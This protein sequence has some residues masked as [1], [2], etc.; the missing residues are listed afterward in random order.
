MTKIFHQ[1]GYR[2]KWNIESISDEGTGDGFIAAPRYMP[3]HTISDINLSLRERSLFDPQFY[4]PNSQ[5][6]FLSE[7]DFF[8]D[9]VADGFTTSGYGD[10]EKL[11]SARLCLQFQVDLSFERLIIPTRYREATPSDFIDTQLEL[12]VEPFLYTYHELNLTTPLLLQLILNDSMLKDNA[13]RNNILNWATGIDEIKGVYLIPQLVRR[14][15]QV[16]DIDYLLGLLEFIR[17]LR[18]NKMEV[19]VGY[20]NTEAILLLVAD[21]TAVTIGSY[22]NLRMFDLRAFEGQEDQ[23]IRGPTAR[24][25]V[26]RLLQW[27]S[28][29]YIGA[30]SRVVTDPSHFFD[31]SR[32]RV[33]MFEPTYNWHFQKSEPYK[34]YFL[35]FSD[36][37]RNVS[38]LPV[39]DRITYLEGLF[40]S[41]LEEFRQLEEAGVILDTDSSGNHLPAWHTALNLYQR[42]L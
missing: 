38:S 1:L 9:V 36:Q 20:L 16:D 21:P 25:Y 41:A 7:Y 33:T 40:I 30:I 24:I 17:H 23:Q 19:V 39:P 22:E 29:Q 27:V 2:Y 6:G 37:L 12:F 11:E 32:Y 4:L 42:Q 26:T 8:P 10:E 31:E 35:V 34:H 13:F 15:K 14:K 3:I 18:I 5:Q 28:H